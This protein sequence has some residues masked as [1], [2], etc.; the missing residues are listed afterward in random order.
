MYRLASIL[1]LLIATTLS[2][3]F[4]VICLTFGFG[5]SLVLSLATATGALLAAPLAWILTQELAR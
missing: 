2:G 5:S 4:I 3:N 1:Y